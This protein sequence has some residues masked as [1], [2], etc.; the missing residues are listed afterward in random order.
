MK[1]YTM[2]STVRNTVMTLALAFPQVGGT[3]DTAMND[4]GVAGT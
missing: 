3:P 1:A 2:K 4:A